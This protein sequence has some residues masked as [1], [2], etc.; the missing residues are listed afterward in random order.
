[1]WVSWILQG[2]FKEDAEGWRT[3]LLEICGLRGDVEPFCVVNS[4]I[5]RQ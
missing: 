1:L 3:A 2:G 4:P 5:I